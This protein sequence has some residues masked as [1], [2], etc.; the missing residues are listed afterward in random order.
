MILISRIYR[1]VFVLHFYL[2]SLILIY[3]VGDPIGALRLYDGAISTDGRL[4]M[5]KFVL[6]ADLESSQ[7]RTS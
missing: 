1:P 2:F 5:C 7:S 3:F 6:V 4:A